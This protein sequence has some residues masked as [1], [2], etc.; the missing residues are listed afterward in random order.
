MRVM[1]REI[2]RRVPDLEITGAPELLRS[3]LVHKIKRVGCEWR[4]VGMSRRETQTDVLG[5][6]I[7]SPSAGQYV[8]TRG[9]DDALRA[10]R[11]ASA[12]RR[13]L[14]PQH[15]GRRESNERAV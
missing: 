10:D 7:S 2:A 15:L 12:Q 1:F 9:A 3:N 11:P 6:G 8:A 14:A 4:V 13:L 5:H